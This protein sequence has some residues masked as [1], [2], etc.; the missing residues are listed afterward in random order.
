[1]NTF[2]TEENAIPQQARAERLRR[3]RNMANLSREE[4]CN[5]DALNVATYKGW[6][7]GR[8]GGLSSSGAK[9][10]IKRIAKEGVVCSLDWLLHG[11]GCGP[12]IIANTSSV[13]NNDDD[14][15]SILQEI[16]V[17]QN[18]FKDGIFLEVLDDGMLPQYKPRDF[19]AGIKKYDTE[20]NSLIGDICIV[21]SVDNEIMIR[22]LLKG[23]TKNTYTMICLN[24]KT[25]VAFPVL[26]NVEI[27]AAALIVRHY[28]NP[29]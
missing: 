6:E 1:M 2:N 13:R 4:L 8:F 26:F 14:I 17:F 3:L 5:T 11:Q 22:Q 29:L 12:F 24:P 15:P 23:I 18:N 21:Q 20:I 27:K 28:K 7:I 16:T 10:V 9:E 19:V 25:T